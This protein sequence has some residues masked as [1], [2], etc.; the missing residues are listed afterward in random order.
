MNTKC[1]L[2][3]A[4]D[5]QRSKAMGLIDIINLISLISTVLFLIVLMAELTAKSYEQEMSIS[6]FDKEQSDE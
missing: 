3:V 1:V 2:N 5:T 4:K 6:N